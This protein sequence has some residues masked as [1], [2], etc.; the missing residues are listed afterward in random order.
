MI[1]HGI[2]PCPGIT[3]FET[4]NSTQYQGGAISPEYTPYLIYYQALMNLLFENR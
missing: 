1:A 3:G 4:Y 2:V